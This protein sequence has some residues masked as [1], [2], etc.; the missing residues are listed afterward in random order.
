MNAPSDV[1]VLDATEP[2]PYP[3]TET[4]PSPVPE[5]GTN[6]AGIGGPGNNSNG[7]V[8]PGAYGPGDGPR[9]V[10]VLGGWASK[11]DRP[12]W[13]PGWAHDIRSTLAA[14]VDH[15]LYVCKFHSARI[16][17]YVGRFIAATPRGIG[18]SVSRLAAWGTDAERHE[19]MRDAYRQRNTP[20]Y[21]QLR[22]Q[23]TEDLKTRAPAA[24]FIGI[25]VP[26]VL[27][28]LV[29]TGP[30]WL[31]LA[32]LAGCVAGFGLAGRRPGRPLVDSAIQAEARGRKPSPEILTK[33]FIAARLA[34]EKDP[35]SFFGDVRRDGQGWRAVI[36]LPAGKTAIEAIDRRVNVAS[37]L[38]IDEARLFI[39][40]VR[41]SSGHAGRVVLW[42]ADDDP[43]AGIVPT[44]LLNTKR[45]DVWDPIP[46]GQDERGRLV[47]VSLLWS[48][49]VFGGQPG[50]GK[51]F[52]VRLLVSG[53]SLDPRVVLHIFD[54]KRSPDLR[55]FIPIAHRHGFG[56]DDD[57]CRHL[58]ATVEELVV[59]MDRRYDLISAL[60]VEQAAEGKI[61]RDMGVPL[62]L[63]VLEEC[64]DY[65]GNPNPLAGPG[66]MKLGVAIEAAVTKL[67]KKGRAVGID[68]ILSTQKPDEKA[69]PTA[70]RDN[71]QS[72]FAL[73][74]KTPSANDMVLGPGM[75]AE[76]F[77]AT[78]LRLPHHR[79]V[80]Y[81]V[82][83]AVPADCEASGLT[84]KTHYLD[85]VGATAIVARAL[86]LR[87]AAG[88]LTGQAAGEAVEAPNWS[89][90]D[91]IA[92]TFHTGDESLWWTEILQRMQTNH[93]DRYGKLTVKGLGELAAGFGM[94]PD[95]I[96]RMVD[97]KQS[98]RRGLRI[99]T[100]TD[101]LDRRAQAAA[102]T[103][104]AV[105]ADHR[106]TDGAELDDVDGQGDDLD[107]LDEEAGEGP[108]VA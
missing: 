77:D 61:T 74:L 24:V 44:P 100:V 3:D 79:G 75:R 72:A 98:N 20:Q 6:G 92:N 25:T 89:A 78:K 33:A 102:A 13:R 101:A 86:E 35:I 43:L 38:G 50:S 94:E 60:P 8:V 96:W 39:N 64:Q 9:P 19:L 14:L 54:A 71:I 95:Q 73:K 27:A 66:S 93:R 22:R 30:V 21:N 41:G 48:S 106:P 2:V 103:E 11:A 63:V 46:F 56:D 1:A 53:A 90:L 36:D 23:R 76:G 85:A 83:A 49:W 58:L 62:I 55:P 45:V 67:V 7:G 65:F 17:N 15:V 40:R 5:A 81:L 42:Q 18:Q 10:P 29:L 88:T 108:D 51:T 32:T 34:T 97:G 104:A 52:C 37:A 82:G 12:P 84:V 99:D 28:V 69:V 59:E 68:V 80:G 70:I 91:D 107:E 16:P 105:E 57:T 4:D 26:T 87:R 47:T 31:R